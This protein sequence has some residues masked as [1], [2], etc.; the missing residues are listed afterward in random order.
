VKVETSAPQAFVMHGLMA[1]DE[2][3][4]AALPDAD[5]L[6]L[7][8]EGLL[9]PIYAHLLSLAAVDRLPEGLPRPLSGDKL[10]PGWRASACRATMLNPLRRAHG[11]SPGP[12]LDIGLSF[13]ANRLANAAV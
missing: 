12:N 2:W 6:D 8:R 9:A 13:F 10:W 3:H 7:R 4:L 1:V 5:F 11:P